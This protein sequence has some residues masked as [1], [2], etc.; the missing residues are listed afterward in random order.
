MTKYKFLIPVYNDWQSLNLLL[1]NL[2]NELKST[3]KTG[4]I[5]IVDDGSTSAPDLKINNLSNIEKI[6]LITLNENLG[7]QKSI[8]I[9]LKHLENENISEIVTVMDSDGEDDPSKVNEMINVAEGNH[10]K[11]ITSNRTSRKENLLFRIL[12]L[13]HKF[14][15]YVLSTHWI[16]FG[17]FSSFHSKN[18]P[19]ILKD[20]KVWLAYSS[21]ISSNCKIKRVYAKRKKR[22][23]GQSKVNFWALVLHSL[24]IISVLHSKVILFS[25]MYIL[26]LILISMLFKNIIFLFLIIL[27]VIFNLALLYIKSKNNVSELNNW[28]NYIKNIN[29]IN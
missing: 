28:K 8:A 10:N 21:A 16:S 15:T 11:V 25:L 24:R 29:N 17:N 20:N 4:L 27:I 1:E 7:S 2:N 6:E 19:N 18:L 22:Y 14:L 13:F 26:I 5:L 23:F 12:Y 9:G 3:F